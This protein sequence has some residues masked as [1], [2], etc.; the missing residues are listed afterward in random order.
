MEQSGLPGSRLPRTEDARLLAGAGSY[1][2]DLTVPGMAHACFV[3]SPYAH[4]SIV[5]LDAGAARD[6]PGVRAVLSAADLPH[7]PLVDSVAVPGL[8]KTPQPALAS[9]K[10]RFVGET[11]AI[12]LADSR[13]IAEDAAELVRVEYDPLPVATDPEA[14][15]DGR[16]AAIFDHV[17]G[18]VVYEGRREHGDV[19]AAFAR[20]AHVVGGRF[21]T[22]RFVAA[23]MEGR[24]CLAEYDRAT[25]RL[26]VHCSTQ[27]PHLLRRKLAA[28]LELGEGRIRVLVPDVGGG[29]GQK[30]PAA[31]EEVAVALAARATGLPVRWVEDRR[32]NIT[33]APHAKDQIIDLELAVAADGTFEAIRA[34]ILGDSGAYSYNSASTLIECYLSAGLL[35]GPYRIRDVEW[36]V[37]A[38]LTNKTPV[39]AYRGVGWTASHS[40][41]EVLVDRAARLLGRDPLDLRRQNLVREYPYTSATGMVYDS[42]SVAES[43]D[44]AAE[45]IRHA[46][47]GERRAA[48]E[49]RG[50]RL[51]VG[52]SPYVEPSAWGSAG[53]LQSSWSFPSHDHVR[54]TME[55]SGEVTAAVGTPSQGQGHATTLAQVI[56]GVLGVDPAAVTVLANDTAA[57]PISTAGTRASRTATVIGGALTIASQELRGKLATLAAG[58]LEC[59]PGDLVFGD[60]RVQVRG[61]PG[62]GIALAE[63]AERAHFDLAAR[64]VLGEPALVATGFYDPPATYSNGCVAVVVEVDPLTGEVAVVDAAAVEDCGTMINPTIVEGQV[65]GAFAQGVGGALYEHVPYAADGTP[66]ATSFADYLLPTAV[67]LPHVRLGHCVSPS[68]LTVGGVKGMGESGLIAT[69]AAVACAVADALAP[70]GVEIDRTPVTPGYLAGLLSP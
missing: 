34:R 46:D 53:A 35:P 36:Q 64:A 10:V 54:V 60:G 44:K 45:L 27:S 4:A 52:I 49:K 26:T 21:T 22:G 42:G 18:D 19:A 66:L 41:R 38:V 39:S 5:S 8:L 48:T 15:R 7:R 43:T 30:I 32:E 37:T 12:V 20:A 63:L 50:R 61:T 24:G 13:A 58:L 14:V 16:T 25:D 55:P 33:A 47:L 6:L 68:P 62:I 1:L 23:P 57:I 40:A 69:P 51:G 9:E 56:S 28:C 11:V 70:L 67:E 3:R 29:F 59:D 17:P 2:A 31:P 65:L